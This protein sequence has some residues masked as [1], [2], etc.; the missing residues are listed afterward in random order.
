MKRKLRALVCRTMLCAN[1]F[2]IAGLIVTGYSAIINPAH[3]PY[4]SLIGFSFPAFMFGNFCFVA[5]WL[6]T[7]IRYVLVPLGGFLLAYSPCKTYF[8]LNFSG[9]DED[10]Y[11]DV[12]D[13]LPNGTLKVLT[14]N[15]LG[16]NFSESP[17]TQPNEILDYIV[18]SGADI[19]CVQEYHEPYGQ[20]SLNAVMQQRYQY[21]DTIHSDGFKKGNDVVGVFSK[22]PIIGK[23]HIPIY[24]RGN[25]LGVFDLDIDGDTVHVIN[26]HLE[27]VGM[28][29][30]Q[31]AKF[32]ELVHGRNG[33]EQMKSDSKMIIHKLAESAA[34]RA[35]QADAINAYIRKHKGERIIFCGDIN[36][37]PL[38]YVHHT[39]AERLTDCYR[40]AGLYSGYTFQYNSM[41]VRIDNIMCSEHYKPALCK[42]DKSITLSDHFPLYCIL[43]P[44]KDK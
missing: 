31:K 32:S 15:I 3:H 22:F 35:P 13:R 19:V 42:V 34:M 6:V 18:N 30:D 23:E 44:K 40:E 4:V 8:P 39:I 27:T 17:R 11:Y 21:T 29:P 10:E 16:F 25:S 43:E 33:K 20:D 41:Y 26:A 14:Y 7:R 9:N 1:I 38:S 24:T 28:S 36:D 12:D 2:I 37:H 5:F